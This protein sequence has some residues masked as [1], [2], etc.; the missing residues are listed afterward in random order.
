MLG[1]TTDSSRLWKSKV[2][3]L[4]ARAL[5]VSLLYYGGTHSLECM[6]R[7]RAV[8]SIVQYR[9]L[10]VLLLFDGHSLMILRSIP[11]D[12]QYDKV[13]LVFETRVSKYM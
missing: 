4:T 2:R 8:N 12:K 13:R 1:Q 10:L 5:S 7:Y 9:L 6:F 3:R 11:Y